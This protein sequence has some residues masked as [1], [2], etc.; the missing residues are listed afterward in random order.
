[1]TTPLP[2]PGDQNPYQQQPYLYAQGQPP[3]PPPKKNM[4]WL[5]VLLGA[6]GV[7]IV[8]CGLGAVAIFSGGNRDTD[9]GGQGGAAPGT[10][11]PQATSHAIG[12]PVR[13]GKFEFVV[14]GVQ[15]GVEQVGQDFLIERAQGQFCL[16]TL[17]IK[18]VGDE[19]QTMFDRDQKGF[20]TNGLEYGANSAAGIAANDTG[21]QVWVTD[22]NPGNE[23]TGVVVYD[24]PK[25]VELAQVELHDSTPSD[26]VTVDLK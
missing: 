19:P 2:P 5:W 14:R 11:S 9:P 3:P 18:N 21:S 10:P 15:C 7:I 1:M 24:L 4:A 20:G 8:C 16:M 22:I 25:G 23:L 17:S 13:D 26:G 6:A 12:E